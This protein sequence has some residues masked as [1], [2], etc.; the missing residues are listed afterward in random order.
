MN[1]AERILAIYDRLIQQQQDL[2]MQEVWAQVLEIPLDGPNAED[3]LATCLMALR[4]EIHLARALLQEHGVPDRLH[5]PGFDMLHQVAAP[6]GL[7]TAWSGVRGN[8]VQPHQRISIDWACWVLEDEREGDVDAADRAALAADLAE[9]ETKLA[10][11]S[12]TPF[13]AAFHRRQIDVIRKGLRL[14][15][16]RGTGPLKDSLRSVVGDMRV[17]DKRLKAE[18][19]AAPEQNKGLMARAAGIIDKAVKIAEKGSKLKKGAEDIGALAG[20]A[21]EQFESI[22]GSVQALLTYLPPSPPP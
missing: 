14:Y 4:A 18:L 15:D 7:A 16:I 13:M 3:E 2:R 5:G 21:K 1:P 11:A 10:D 20:A 9:L 6:G 22:A 12:A 19:E 17:E 8:I